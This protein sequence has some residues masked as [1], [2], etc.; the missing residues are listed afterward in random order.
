MTLPLPLYFAHRNYVDHGIF[1]PSLLGAE[2][3]R[4][5]LHS[6]FLAAETGT[7]YTAMTQRIRIADKIEADKLSEQICFYGRL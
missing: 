7:D 1:I 3:V 6:R 2:T 4:E 5:Y